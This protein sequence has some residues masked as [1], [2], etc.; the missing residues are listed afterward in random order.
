M[1][2]AIEGIDGSGKETQT[3]R[4]RDMLNDDG[5]VMN[6]LS[7]P[8][9]SRTF[10]GAIVGRYLNGDFGS[11]VHPLFASLLFA[12]DQLEQAPA[13]GKLLATSDV[14]IADR[15]S[16]SNLAHQGARLEPELRP[17][18][19]ELLSTLEHSIFG[20]LRPDMTILIDL[21][22]NEAGR[23]IAAKKPRSHTDKPADIHEADLDYLDR[24]RCEYLDLAKLRDIPVITSTS[25]GVYK[26]QHDIAVEIYSLVMKR[27]RPAPLAAET[28]FPQIDRTKL[29]QAIH[30]AW[31]TK[32]WHELIPQ[33]QADALREADAALVDISRQLSLVNS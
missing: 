21:D 6:S 22:A 23:R 33:D 1:F 20:T 28:V 24:V 17:G 19:R 7:F 30:A 11:S 2:I 14:V 12:I 10:F 15:Y 3:K 26:S 25:G 31:S 27:L 13:I 32:R 9:Y 5:F 18:F 29:A 16:L 8:G 4:L